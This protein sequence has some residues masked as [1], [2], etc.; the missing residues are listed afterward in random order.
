MKTLMFM[1]HR[2]CVYV[3]QLFHLL[4]PNKCYAVCWFSEFPLHF[5]QWIKPDICIP[6]SVRVRSLGS[7]DTVCV[8]FVTFQ[9][10]NKVY[11]VGICDGIST[12]GFLWAAADEE[13]ILRYTESG[14]IRVIIETLNGCQYIYIKDNILRNN[15]RLFDM[16]YCRSGSPF[17][18]L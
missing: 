4:L 1:V 10:G 15:N 13:Q 7:S 18:S 8:Y 14:S 2:I 9:D 16:L 11:T 12:E 5:S 17:S 6:Y 3:Y